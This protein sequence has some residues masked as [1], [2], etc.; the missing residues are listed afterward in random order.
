MQLS[1]LAGIGKS[2]MDQLI[3]LHGESG[4]L[5]ARSTFTG[6]EIRGV[7]EGDE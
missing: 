1:A 6:A 3:T 7:R 5:E 4:T 2:D